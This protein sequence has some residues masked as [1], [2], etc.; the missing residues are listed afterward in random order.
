MLGLYNNM[1]LNEVAGA[2][3]DDK[4]CG[5][6]TST[7]DANFSNDMTTL[8]NFHHFGD[9]DP[10]LMSQLSFMEKIIQ[11]PELQVPEPLIKNVV[12]SARLNCP[13]DLKLVALKARNAEYNPKRFPAVIMRLR[14]PKTTALI[15][16]SGKMI[17][18]GAKTVDN[19]KLAMR[20]FAKI[21][22]HLNF[23]IKF[24]DFKVVNLLA[25]VDVKFPVRLEGFLNSKHKMFCTYE[26]ELFPA[27]IYRVVNPKCVALI[28]ACGRVI[29]TGARTID[30]INCAFND[31]YT[32][33]H[34]F[35]KT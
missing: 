1:D 2:S 12:A 30:D 8:N 6:M 7:N 21:L 34:E 27:L 9:M 5:T 17:C 16:A 35:K 23:D 15:Y 26:P 32:V 14:D 24:T 18:M 29:L 25:S 19:A 11:E 13:I 10:A 33:I 31:L 4:L 3:F 22:K 28:F 20:K